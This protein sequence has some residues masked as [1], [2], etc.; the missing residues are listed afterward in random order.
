M[1]DKIKKTERFVSSLFVLAVFMSWGATMC[2][3]RMF[4]IIPATYTEIISNPIPTVLSMGFYVAWLIW[5]GRQ[6]N[7]RVLRG[8]LF[9]TNME[10]EG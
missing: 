3:S 7:I 9:P 6:S 4:N 8:F 10:A 2:I 1:R 5:L